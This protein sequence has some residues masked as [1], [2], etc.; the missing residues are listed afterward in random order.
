MLLRS[1]RIDDFHRDFFPA[2]LCN[3]TYKRADLTSN[4]PLSADDLADIRRRNA[5]PEQT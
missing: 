2:S 1:L 3:G 4:A 5:V